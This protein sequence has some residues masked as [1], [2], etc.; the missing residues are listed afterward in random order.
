MS[1]VETSVHVRTTTDADA[2]AMAELIGELGYPARAAELP[3][4]LARMRAHSIA[5]KRLAS[6]NG[7]ASSRRVA[8][9]SSD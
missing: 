1:P 4:R 5:S 7:S 9:S 2:A 8:D 6:T 3:D